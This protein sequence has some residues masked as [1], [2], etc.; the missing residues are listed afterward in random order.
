MTSY[1]VRWVQEIARR[2]R[3]GPEAIGDHRHTNPG[4]PPLLDAVQQ[5]QLHA[6]PGR[7]PAGVGGCG[8]AEG[9][10]LAEP[11][12]WGGRSATHGLGMDAWRWA[13]PCSGHDP[14]VPADPGG[15][16]GFKKGGL[17]PPSRT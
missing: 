10:A 4:A 3:A 7:T 5:A 11:D 14:A 9:G 17:P 6:A 2:Y 1:S 13:S 15:Q 12:R 8:P 16:A